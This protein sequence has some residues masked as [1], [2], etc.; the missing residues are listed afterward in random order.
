[1][2]VIER[3]REWTPEGLIT[4]YDW[5][6]EESGYHFPDHLFPVALA[7]C[8]TR[9]TKVM[10]TVG[11]G[12]GKSQLMSIVYPAAQ[13]GKRPTDAI[14][15]VSGAENLMQGFQE[16]V[17]RFI[18]DPTGPFRKVFPHVLPDKSAGWSIT[19]GMNVIGRRSGSPDAS[20]WGAGLQST[21]L[22]GK[23][24][25]VL[26]FD[27]LHDEQNSATEEQC[28]AVVK[29]YAMQLTG[30]AD[31]RGAR[32]LMAGRRWHEKDLYG[33]LQ[34]NGDWVTLTLPAERPG[35]KRLYWDVTVPE[36]IECVFTDGFMRLGNG[37]IVLASSIVPPPTKVTVDEKSTARIR[38]IEWQYGI[39][40]KSQGFYWPEMDQKRQE[41]FTNKVLAP[42]ETEATYQ[43]NPG[44]RQGVVFTDDDFARR[45]IPPEGMESGVAMPAVKEF[46]E[47]GSFLIQAWDT[48]F[49]ATST[50]DYTVGVTLL[51]VPC[52]EW[53]RDEAETLGECEP[54]LDVYLMDIYRERIPYSGVTAAMRQQFMKWHPSFVVIEKK[55][56]G[57]VA[58]EAL[59]GVLPIESVTP[60]PLESKRARAVE[61]LTGGSVQ[62]WC[63]M[64]RVVVPEYAEWLPAFLR[65]MKNFTGAKGNTD[66]QVDALV[67][68]VRWAISNGGTALPI[69]GDWADPNKI[70]DLM[71]PDPHAMSM[72]ARFD[73]L[74][75]D[76][77]D[78]FG[79]C[80]GNC[81]H[82]LR[83]IRDLKIPTN[84]RFDGKPPDYCTWHDRGTVG[85]G[86][87]DEGFTDIQDAMTFP[88]S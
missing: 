29:K 32:M 73:R 80:C 4:L 69:S 25:T 62:G 78:P 23:H 57:V 34:G 56:Y 63:R 54:H 77:V 66:D 36:G 40:P 12:S 50:S 1:M 68:G 72:A 35:S 55:A 31:P 49:S 75:V 14:I 70:D 58:I 84:R 18:D 33:T 15:G 22:T 61:G 11:P 27:D 46:V 19:K 52:L 7:L 60:G 16:T 24:G 82:F 86:S 71:R 10:V 81:R 87:C 13:L 5:L 20:Y 6:M 65:E 21:A 17:M 64:R 51:L 3:C 76:V 67:H 30:R 85:I 41:Y 44:A 79:E 42:A 28:Q 26:I 53:H 47:Q 8:D 37:D 48:A 43:C 38:H 83:N 9:L 88:V 39:D 74:A 45:F 59:E 2:D